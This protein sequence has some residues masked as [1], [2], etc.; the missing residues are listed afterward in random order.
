MKMLTTFRI[1]VDCLYK[2]KN[3]LKSCYGP[4]T[5]LAC[6]VI[7]NFINSVLQMQQLNLLFVDTFSYWYFFGLT[8]FFVCKLCVYALA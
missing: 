6:F 3:M 5:M 4:T 8:I 7:A 1:Y 2:K